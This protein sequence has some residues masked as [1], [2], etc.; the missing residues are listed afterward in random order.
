MS[1]WISQKGSKSVSLKIH[2]KRVTHMW[3]VMGFL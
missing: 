3:P 1:N 2:D